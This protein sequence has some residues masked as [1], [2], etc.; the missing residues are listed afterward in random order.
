MPGSVEPMEVD[1]E[2][3]SESVDAAK[4]SKVATGISGDA[5]TASHDSIPQRHMTNG[6]TIN[7]TTNGNHQES[8]SPLS[9]GASDSDVHNGP[10]V[11]VNGNGNGRIKVLEEKVLVPEVEERRH[12]T[13]SPAKRNRENT[14]S[15]TGGD[16]VM[17]AAESIKQEKE[18]LR[19]KEVL[20]DVSPE[21]VQ[22]AF[23]DNWRQIVFEGNHETHVAFIARAVLKNAS[24]SVL[25]RIGKDDGIFKGALLEAAIHKPVV[26][27]NVFKRMDHTQIMKQISKPV[28][29]KIILQSL[30]D[31]D[32]KTL[33]G[34]LST[35][36]RLGY[37]PGDVLDPYVELVIPSII[38]DSQDVQMANSHPQNPP[39]IQMPL[40]QIPQYHPQQYP[41]PPPNG[42][43]PPVFHH[44]YG[45]HA[46]PPPPPRP[47]ERPPI[48]KGMMVC[49]YCYMQFNNRSGFNYHVH[50]RIC[51][52]DP[53]NGQ[54]KFACGL[55]AQ[56]FTTKQ[57]REYHNAKGVCEDCNIEPAT[58]PAEDE[59]PPPPSRTPSGPAPQ[60][61]VAVARPTFTMAPINPSLTAPTPVPAPA[62]S[63]TP[64]KESSRTPGSIPR[65]PLHTPSTR[66]Q[67]PPSDIRQSPSELPPERL[68]AL[69]RELQD[70]DA[71][72]QRLVADA[73]TLPAAERAA[74]LI[75]LKNG[76]ASRK[77]QIRKRYG[78]SLRLRDKDKA[79]KRT[80]LPS[81]PSGLVEEFR[82]P[83]PPEV[84][85]RP[86]SGFSPINV[87][88][89][90]GAQKY[91]SRYP[92]VP[93]QP[94]PS[95][96]SLPS[97]FRPANATN[98]RYPEQNQLTTSNFKAQRNNKR[99]R[100]ET[101]DGDNSR[102][103]SAPFSRPSSTAPLTMQHVRTENAAAKFPKKLLQNSQAKWSALQPSKS[104]SKSGSPKTNG[105][106]GQK[107]EGAIL[108]DSDSSD[109]EVI[110]AATA[111]TAPAVPEQAESAEAAADT[112]VAS[113]ESDDNAKDN[114]DH[115]D[116]TEEDEGAN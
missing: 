77:S 31:A 54:W 64:A 2:R 93:S 45:P 78:V 14:M 113:I 99:R 76:N 65:P 84:V 42:A 102:Q 112:V 6:Q 75:S 56:G 40:Q 63:A 58:P 44:Q 15:S 79:A 96:Q 1:V 59:R 115:G 51:S 9:N 71:K 55:C 23:R 16:Y 106:L 30:E 47:M 29:D 90:N 57:G 110:L 36:G 61:Q 20:N 48:P 70:E 111:A 100:S 12:V 73:Q 52:K 22:K 10:A 91:T 87:V 89:K 98:T 88:V 38:E 67:E 26:V 62:A 60:A 86:T 3:A 53:G 39:P 35:A 32:A 101:D 105:A 103:S 97:G 24:P 43:S 17:T 7:G 28:L 46:P 41:P 69:N 66:R 107:K 80:S 95:R 21:A 19:V 34:W 4:N 68:Q 18:V 11:H 82:A 25:D 109:S 114:H 94:T 8:S 92:P 108:I 27:Q 104:K 85:E 116:S 37:K 50:K 33:L 74:R 13:L 83:S 72:Y 5:S 81:R 49:P